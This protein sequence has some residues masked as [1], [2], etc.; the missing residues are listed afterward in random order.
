[1]TPSQS[2][3]RLDEVIEIV[4]EPISLAQVIKNIISNASIHGYDESNATSGTITVSVERAEEI[5]RIVVADDGC[6][7]SDEHFPRIFEPFFTT[8]QSTENSGLGLS[9]AQNLVTR[10]LGGHIDCHSEVGN[11]A[12][13]VI[14][15]PSS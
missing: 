6:G 3:D 10:R 14:S 2:H 1:M 9:I 11:G 5:T 4:L 8:S 7:I 15:L 13:F 12:T